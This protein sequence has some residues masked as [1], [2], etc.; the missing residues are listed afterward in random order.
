[1][2]EILEANGWSISVNNLGLPDYAYVQM[3]SWYAEFTLGRNSL[4]IWIVDTPD[5]IDYSSDIYIRTCDT[6]EKLNMA[7]K[8]AGL[9]YRIP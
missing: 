2:K 3:P 6:T 7:F 8:I 5:D 4:N 1:M 9:N